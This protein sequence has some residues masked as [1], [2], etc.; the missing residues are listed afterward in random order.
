MP[1]ILIRVYCILLGFYNLAEV[2]KMDLDEMI[3][4]LAI[5]PIHA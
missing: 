4:F 2:I 5:S 1:Y 3:S